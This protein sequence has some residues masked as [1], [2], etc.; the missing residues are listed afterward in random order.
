VTKTFYIWFLFLF[1]WKRKHD[2]SIGYFRS[3]TSNNMH[4]S[5]M[6]SN[7]RGWSYIWK[8]SPT[9][10]IWCVPHKKNLNC[11]IYTLSWKCFIIIKC[12]SELL[13]YF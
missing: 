4:C 11:F 10:D 12:K 7:W 6:G 2:L 9:E 1:L 5:R 3:V 13:K 8:C